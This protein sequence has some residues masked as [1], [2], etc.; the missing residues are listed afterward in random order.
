M[1]RPTI[2][3]HF[4]DGATLESVHKAYLDNPELFK[5]AQALDNY[6]DHLEQPTSISEEEIE[7]YA[8]EEIDA[9]HPILRKYYDQQRQLIID[10]VKWTLT[11]IK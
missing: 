5:Y 7:K 2:K 10:A 6:I 3:Q 11:N 4:G 9:K 8:H 1:N